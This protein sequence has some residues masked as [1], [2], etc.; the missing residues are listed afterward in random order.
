VK[1]HCDGMSSRL[2]D[3]WGEGVTRPP[4]QAAAGVVTRR[5]FRDSELGARWVRGVMTPVGRRDAS[6]C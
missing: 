4:P 3:G 6:L 1:S 2:R 5:A